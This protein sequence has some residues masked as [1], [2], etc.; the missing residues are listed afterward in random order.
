MTTPAVQF[1]SD[2]KAAGARL[3]AVAR[4][5]RDTLGLDDEAAELETIAYTYF[6]LAPKPT[7]AEYNDL[8]PTTR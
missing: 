7:D 2:R 5:L 4:F 3:Y 6:P 1:L 8:Y